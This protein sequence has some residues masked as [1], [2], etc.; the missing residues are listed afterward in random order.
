MM[1][2]MMAR[3]SVLR[4]MED[5]E[6]ERERGHMREGEGGYTREV[7]TWYRQPYTRGRV[8]KVE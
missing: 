1:Q 6:R 7:E 4:A 3:E 5:M 2:D 8:S